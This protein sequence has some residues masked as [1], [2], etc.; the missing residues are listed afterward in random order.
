M[1]CFAVRQ[2]EGQ[3]HDCKCKRI[4]SKHTAVQ[5]ADKPFLGT[6]S[7]S[8]TATATQN[9]A[10]QAHNKTRRSCCKYVHLRGQLPDHAGVNL[11][12]QLTPEVE[13][14][15]EGLGLEGGLQGRHCHLQLLTGGKQRE[16]HK[17]VGAQLLGPPQQA[18]PYSREHAML[19]AV[20]WERQ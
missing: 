18:A 9:V 1:S 11:Q 2:S 17:G 3:G 14:R 19:R 4:S 16:V 13:L 5:M 15:A 12:R 7:C 20:S 8:G 6:Y 10:Q